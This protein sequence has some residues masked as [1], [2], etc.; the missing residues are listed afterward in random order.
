MMVSFNSGNKWYPGEGKV[1][2]IHG[3]YNTIH[4]LSNDRVVFYEKYNPALPG[5]VWASYPQIC[6]LYYN[7]K[8]EFSFIYRYFY[9]ASNNPLNR[10]VQDVE[11]IGDYVVLLTFLGEVMIYGDHGTEYISATPLPESDVISVAFP[12]KT[13]GF[14]GSSKGKL[15]RTDDGNNSW[16]TILADPHEPAIV[17]ISF[18]DEKLGFALTNTN[19]LY[20]TVDGGENWSK[21]TLPHRS[22]KEDIYHMVKKRV[23]MVDALRGFTNYDKEVF[24]TVDGGL[25]W[26][27]SL[28]IGNTTVNAISYDM[29]GHLWAVTTRGLIKVEL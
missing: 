1:Y 6:A 25:T 11:S 16:E 29:K 18:F 28:R 5:N 20:R 22:Q 19:V 12:T 26:T 7:F 21:I 24:E 23:V 10:I 2:I 3:S 8:Q 14:V 15:L 4:P 27:R 13:T 9:N 17:E